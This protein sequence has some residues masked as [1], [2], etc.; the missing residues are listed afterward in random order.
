M[1]S[2]K[3]F[4]ATAILAGVMIFSVPPAL[5]QVSVPVPGKHFGFMPGS[6]YNL[7]SYEELIDY[8]M[9]L[10]K[11]SPMV[12]MEEIGTSP[13]GRKMYIAFISSEKNIKNL[14][15]LR[16]INRELALNPSLSDAQEE[17]VYR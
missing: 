11:A 5:A 14:P 12:S 3:L 10:D 17:R 1:K 2:L 13:M 9:K 4:S 8:L 16:E 15:K 7:F 6:D